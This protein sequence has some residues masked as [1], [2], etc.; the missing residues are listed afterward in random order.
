MSTPLR[1]APPSRGKLALRIAALVILTAN[2]FYPPL[3]HLLTGMPTEVEISRKYVTLFTPAGYA[4]SIWGLIYAAFVAY[5]VYAL[6][7]SQRANGAHDHI[8]PSLIAYSLL[9]IAW[10]T[11]F[12]AE[13]LVASVAIIIGMSAAGVMM[14][15]RVSQAIVRGELSPAWRMPFSLYLGWISVATIANMAVLL[16]A[17]DWRGGAWG[18]TAWT[19]LLLGV[20]TLLGLAVGLR[21]RDVIY[22][23]VIAWATLAI[24]VARRGDQP[25]VAAAAWSTGVVLIGWIALLLIDRYL[26][27]HPK[28]AG[29]PQTSG[30]PGVLPS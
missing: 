17:H 21:E 12:R 24:Y 1:N 3:H 27:H 25:D 28:N 9:G 4:F 30:A 2:I 23:G 8:A 10:I 7:P 29:S 20:A 26:P 13:W 16:V 22:P 19:E 18:E 6:T 15:L 11:A 14:Y 5:A